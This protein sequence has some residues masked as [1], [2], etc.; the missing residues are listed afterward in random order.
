MIT[1]E[2][3]QRAYNLAVDLGLEITTR[4]TAPGSTTWR[5]G[6]RGSADQYCKSFDTAQHAAVHFLTTREAAGAFR[7]RQSRDDALVLECRQALESI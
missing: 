5:Y 1:D 6:M 3:K 7:V 2:L 4:D